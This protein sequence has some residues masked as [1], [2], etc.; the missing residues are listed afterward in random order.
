MGLNPR[1]SRKPEEKAPVPHPLCAEAQA[2][3]VPCYELGRFCEVC[4][5]GRPAPSCDCGHK[6][7]KSG[8]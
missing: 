8:K 7:G 4:E 6:H 2:D 1:E 3:G 5:R